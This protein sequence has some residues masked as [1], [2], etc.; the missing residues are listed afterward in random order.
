MDKSVHQLTAAANHSRFRA[1]K[2][3]FY[4][5]Y[6]LRANHPDKPQAFWIRYTVFEPRDAAVPTIGELWATWFDGETGRHVSVKTERPIFECRFDPDRFNMYVGDA[7]LDDG[8]AAGAA[9]AEDVI[10]WELS[11]KGDSKPLFLLPY[12][13][14]ETGFPKAKALVGL[15]MAVFNGRLTVNGSTVNIHDWVGSQN[16]NW[17]VKHTDSYAWGQV[18]GFDNSPDSFLELATAQLKFGPVKTPRMTLVVFRHK[19]R[20][21]RLNSIMQ[22]LKAVGRFDYFKWAFKSSAKE[23]SIQGTILAGKHDFVGLRYYNPPGGIKYC[24]NT[25]IAA[26]RMTIST[27]RRTD[28]LVLETKSR[29]AFEIFTDDHQAHGV[30]IFA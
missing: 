3:G 20:E 21:Y 24:L 26:C 23:L 5:S 8:N 27:G 2:K 22:S 7:L 18:A 15:P 29:A 12:K 19:G 14:Y 16:H 28:R 6:F 17:G 11:Y 25:K 9:G 1:D 30:P 13:M 10:A 4:E